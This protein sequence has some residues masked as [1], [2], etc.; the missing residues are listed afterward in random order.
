MAENLTPLE[1]KDIVR[2]LALDLVD[3]MQV[4]RPPVWV[5]SLFKRELPA[6]ESAL[7]AVE[8][9]ADLLAAFYVWSTASGGQLLVPPDMPLVERRYRLASELFRA[10]THALRERLH[11]LPR[12]QAP[13]LNEYAGYFGRVL[14]APDRLVLDYRRQGNTLHGFAETFLI[15]QPVAAERWADPILA[16]QGLP[17]SEA[18]FSVS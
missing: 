9:L 4:T 15:P 16:D 10:I 3:H 8:T 14:L 11:G 6:R 2:H 5:E 1:R 18:G 7:C 13:D 17:S 12:L